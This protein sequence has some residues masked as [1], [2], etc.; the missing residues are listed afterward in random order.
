MICLNYFLYIF[1][2]ETIIISL[3]KL[4]FLNESLYINN[5][6]E[7]DS[8]N[9]YNNI[10]LIPGIQD[11]FSLLIEEKKIIYIVTDISEELLNIIT[12]KFPFLSQSIIIISKNITYES[13][14]KIIK[15]CG[16]KCN[17]Y[18]M[19]SIESDFSK[20]ISK[21]IIYNLL[22]INDKYN[23]NLCIKNV[24][25]NF[26]NIKSFS[27]KENIE[28]VPFYVSSKTKHRNKWNELKQ[29]FPI[30]SR[31]TDSSKSKNEMNNADKM[32][33]CD[34]I[35]EDIYNS[36][37]GVLYL[38]KDDENH[39]GSLIEIGMLIGQ[40]K[41]VFLC[42]D[43]IFVN[44]VLFNF[45][46][47][48]NIKYIDNF[49]LFEVIRN[50]QY[51]IN[52]C[53]KEFKYNLMNMLQKYIDRAPGRGRSPGLGRPKKSWVMGKTPG[54]GPTKLNRPGALYIE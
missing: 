16:N 38:E 21:N 43:N 26:I 19:I 9:I 37:F 23:I 33:I 10:E 15:D 12:L 44:E 34:I 18:D 30:L 20:L 53:Y 3:E 1:N 36:S 46:G 54:L 40:N 41:L 27:Y 35:K 22:V 25:P 49:N 6:N 14:I 13:Y 52:P 7:M 8:Q 32:N 42:G 11:F 5:L 47:I 48:I 39:I 28:Y 24:L 4:T 29:Y 31:W 45:D 50:I 17:Y 2:L 51:D